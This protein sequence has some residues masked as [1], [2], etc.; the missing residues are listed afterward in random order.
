M[1]DAATKMNSANM[2][3]EDLRNKGWNDNMSGNGD[4]GTAV[5]DQ[6]PFLKLQDSVP[7]EKSL[8]HLNPNG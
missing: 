7:T 8:P 3:Y 4:M 6:D 5:E 1:N 2:F